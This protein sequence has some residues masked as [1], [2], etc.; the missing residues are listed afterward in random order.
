MQGTSYADF[1]VL[2]FRDRGVEVLYKVGHHRK[3]GSASKAAMR[4]LFVLNNADVLN[5]LRFPPA[6][7]YRHAQ[8]MIKKEVRPRELLIA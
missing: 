1:V 4:K 8:V 6:I 5:A 3:S 2:S 7:A